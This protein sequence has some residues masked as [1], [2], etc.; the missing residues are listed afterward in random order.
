MNKTNL[1]EQSDYNKYL[2]KEFE[3]IKLENIN[4]DNLKEEVK[5]IDNIDETLKLSTNIINQI[6]SDEVGINDK[7]SLYIKELNK[8]SDNSSKLESFKN[9]FIEI[10]ND[11]MD[12]TTDYE[13]YINNL[14]SKDKESYVL[15]E[16][17]DLIYSLQNKHRVNS[18]EE[19]IKIKNQLLK[20]L[21]IIKILI[22]L[23]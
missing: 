21:M 22:R 6:N 11:L 15:K 12:L 14:E 19:L 17:L 3:G 9:K 1:D 2:F 18:I 10:K 4:I 23:Y 20:K 8:I 16:S 5:E 7:L 13:N